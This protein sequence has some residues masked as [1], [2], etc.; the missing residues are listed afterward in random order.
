MYFLELFKILFP[1]YLLNEANF[2]QDFYVN[3]FYLTK[4]QGL[5]F[6]LWLNY[7]FVFCNLTLPT[8]DAL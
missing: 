2:S 5:K 4:I 6:I 7:S 1:V 3:I 8:N